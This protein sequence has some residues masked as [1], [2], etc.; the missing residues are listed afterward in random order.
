MTNQKAKALELHRAGAS[1]SEIAAA[2]GTSKTTAFSWVKE[3][4]KESL[5][6]VQSF[7]VQNNRTFKTPN[8]NSYSNFRSE[9]GGAI[10]VK[11]KEPN[12]VVEQRKRI[13]DLE[14]QTQVLAKQLID[15]ASKHIETTE[16]K[17]L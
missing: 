16:E 12:Y 4:E 9:T 5:S 13:A 10:K 14:A 8:T 17:I 11:V 6:N 15:H 3:A 2:L 1:Y 7:N